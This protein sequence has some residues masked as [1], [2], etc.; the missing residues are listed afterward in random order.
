M[1]TLPETLERLFD[2]PS[3]RIISE[4][5]MEIVGEKL[6]DVLAEYGLGVAVAV[7]HLH[8][9]KIGHITVVEGDKQIDI[10]PDPDRP[11]G[12]DRFAFVR[13]PIRRIR[14]NKP[15]LRRLKIMNPK[16]DP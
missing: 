5:N 14:G 13:I 10:V 6:R 1:A 15:E 3:C 11:D 8:G 2:S 7:A 12:G 9:L 16:A 4:T